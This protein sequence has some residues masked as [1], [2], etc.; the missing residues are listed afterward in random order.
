MTDSEIDAYYNLIINYVG[1]DL[2]TVLPNRN[3]Y[4]FEE[5][6]SEIVLR[7]RN[8]LE[9]AKILLN[10]AHFSEEKS[11]TLEIIQNL[12]NKIKMCDS[13]LVDAEKEAGISS[14]ILAKTEAG[15]F[16][17]ENDFKK[18]KREKRKELKKIMAFIFGDRTD[19]STHGKIMTNNAKLKG[20]IEYKTPQD[21]VRVYAKRIRSNVVYVFG[22]V[23]KKDDWAKSINA[24]LD[25]RIS[26]VNAALVRLKN[27]SDKDI[28][29][30]LD[31][32]A[33]TVGDISE[34]I[35]LGSYRMPSKND[36][37]IEVL[38][39]E[40]SKGPEEEAIDKD[41]INW[42]DWSIIYNIAREIYDEKG[43]VD[44]TDPRAQEID[45]GAWL[46][47]QNENIIAGK[48]PRDQLQD[49]LTLL[50]SN[51]TRKY[52]VSPPK[53]DILLTKIIGDIYEGLYSLPDEDQIKFEED[54]DNRLRHK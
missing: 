8:D 30:L 9:A 43:F 1:D 38:D 45:L 51:G 18:L 12:E 6:M 39:L 47:Q 46:D 35:G 17:F 36:E 19:K 10:E 15:N 37:E 54:L 7:L 41:L 50:S 28:Q 25:N 22:I 3:V 2:Q 27:M 40:E 24:V 34:K 49:L 11:S 20:V 4:G 13:Y 23:T 29:S 42:D 16:F 26:L 5:G 48:I 53:E 21:Q 14:I 52:K 44:L 31:E 32:S 33:P